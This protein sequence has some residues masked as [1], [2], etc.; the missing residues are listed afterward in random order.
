VNNE[1]HLNDQYGTIHSYNCSGSSC[2][3]GATFTYSN[4]SNPLGYT[5]IV[6]NKNRT[7]I[8]G[9]NIYDCSDGCIT[10][11]ASDARAQ[12]LPLSTSTLGAALWK[13]DAPLARHD[14]TRTE[15]AL[16]AGSFYQ[17][18]GFVWACPHKPR[19]TT[20]QSSR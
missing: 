4:G 16:G 6:I 3:A 19:Q 13:A 2:V 8:V 17:F 15:P 5:A 10:G 9:A 14:S 1:V 12:S 11:K 18:P 20:V 7:K